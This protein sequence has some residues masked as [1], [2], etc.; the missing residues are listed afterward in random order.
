M[1]YEVKMSGAT[2]KTGEVVPK[3]GIY[4]FVGYVD[5]NSRAAPPHDD[6][7]ELRLNAGDA[8]PLVPST[9]ESAF[10]RKVG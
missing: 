3:T 7:L 9:K 4:R 6:E 5:F 2:Y 1:H 10:W 8:F